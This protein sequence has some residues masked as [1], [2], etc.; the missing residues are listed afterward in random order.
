MKNFLKKYGYLIYLGVSI[1]MF[2]NHIP[3]LGI[4]M[5]EVLLRISENSY[6][7]N[8][9]KKFV[10]KNAFAFYLGG[11]LNIYDLNLLMIR[12]WFIAIF[13]VMLLKFRKPFNY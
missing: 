10:K 4:A 9:P 3:L 1:W 7:K 12:W 5:M 6:R 2:T 11:F 13:T 8:E